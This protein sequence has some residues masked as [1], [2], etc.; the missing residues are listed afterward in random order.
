MILLTERYIPFKLLRE[1]MVTLN[2]NLGTIFNTQK[3]SIHDGSGIRTL[4]FMKGCPLR[5]LWCSNPESQA[6]GL[7]IMDVKSNCIKCGKCAALCEYNAIDFKTFDID[8]GICTKCGK[9][10]EKCY[11]NA[12]KITG[13][14]VSVRELMELIEKDRVFYRNSAGGVTIGGGEPTMQALFVEELLR[15]CKK[16]NIHT[17]IETCGYGYWSKIQGIF[18]YTDQVFFDLKMMDAK[19]HEVMTGHS[20]KRILQNAENVAKKNIETT[21]RIPLIPGYNDKVDNIRETGKFVKKISDYNDKI[22]IEILPY[23][24]LGKD[25]YQWLGVQC[26]LKEVKKDEKENIETCRKILAEEGCTVV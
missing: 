5:C 22:S 24:D 4:I 13:K 3:F 1:G 10:A 23:H 26:H 20:N 12:K 18:D 21:F 11:A 14:Q 19:E 6:L 16:R 7:E 2:K 9:C 25:K 15:E 17:A 8:R